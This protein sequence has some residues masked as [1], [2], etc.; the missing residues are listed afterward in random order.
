MKLDKGLYK[1]T[2][3]IDQIDGS[4][5][6]ARNILINKIQGAVTNELGF[7]KVHT[8]TR[9]IIGSIPITDDEIIIFSRDDDADTVINNRTVATYYVAIPA[10]M[11][12]DITFTYVNSVGVT[13]SE[14]ISVADLPFPSGG[15]PYTYF[16]NGGVTIT[17]TNSTTPANNFTVVFSDTSNT[18]N[19]IGNLTFGVETGSA[20][21][22]IEEVYYSEIGRFKNNSYTKILESTKL[23]FSSE[24]FIK[25]CYVLNYKKEVII[26]FT[27][28]K[29]PPKI[30]NIDDLPFE[31]DPTSKKLLDEN[32]LVLSYLFPEYSKPRI[33]YNTIL[34]NGGALR[35]G[36]YFLSFAYEL[37]DGSVT[38]YTPLEG[39][40]IVTNSTLEL[41]GS[42]RQDQQ[43]NFDLTSEYDG[44]EPDT[45]TSK[46]IKFI[47]TDIDTRYK[48]VHFSVYKKIG[49]VVTS[50]FV[51]R[52]EIASFVNDEITDDDSIE[53]S[54]DTNVSNENNFEITYTG[55]ETSSTLLLEDISVGNDTYQTAKTIT[56]FDS[57]LFLGNVTTNA[58]FNY[59]PYA[60][61][62][63]AHWE[64]DYVDINSVKGSYKNELFVYNKRGFRPDEVY[65]FYIAFLYNDG[66]WSGAYHIP[67]RD[68][69]LVTVALKDQNNKY[70]NPI[71]I[72]ETIPLK[73]IILGDVSQGIITAGDRTKYERIFNHD[74]GINQDTRYFQTRETARV[75]GRLGFWQNEN[76]K[77]PLDPTTWGETNAGQPVRHHKMPNYAT[78]NGV[79]TSFPD[80]SPD[81]DY[82]G[83]AA[84]TGDLVV[85]A[86]MD[87]CEID[88]RPSMPTKG[89][90]SFWAD[91][92]KN[93]PHNTSYTRRRVKHHLYLYVGTASPTV[94]AGY[95][96]LAETYD[97][98][99]FTDTSGPYAHFLSGTI[100]IAGNMRRGG[101]EH[102]A[103]TP[104][105][106]SAGTLTDLQALYPNLLT[107]KNTNKLADG[108]EMEYEGC[109][110]G[111][112]LNTPI[113][114]LPARSA[115]QYYYLHGNNIG[116]YSDSHIIG[117]YYWLWYKVGGCLKKA[118]QSAIY[119]RRWGEGKR[120]M[121]C[122]RVVSWLDYNHRDISIF[123][124]KEDP[125]V[126]VNWWNATNNQVGS[127]NGNGIKTIRA[128][129]DYNYSAS[130]GNYTTPSF[131]S[132][133]PY[134]AEG[135]ADIK[136]TGT[137]PHVTSSGLS[138][139]TFDDFHYNNSGSLANQAAIGALTSSTM[140]ATSVTGTTPYGIW[141]NGNYTYTASE[142]H[143]LLF[144][145]KYGVEL[146]TK[147]ISISGKPTI[148]HVCIS[149]I[150]KIS[151]Q[152]VSDESTWTRTDVFRNK[153]ANSRSL[154]TEAE[155]NSQQ[156]DTGY[157]DDFKLITST[158]GGDF[159]SEDVGEVF[160]PDFTAAVTLQVGDVI[161]FYHETTCIVNGEVNTN[162]PSNTTLSNR[163]TYDFNIQILSYP[164][165]NPDPVYGPYSM[166][167]SICGVRFSNIEIPRELKDRVQGYQFFYARRDERNTRVYDQSIAFH[168]APHALQPNEEG[169][170]AGHLIPLG[171]LNL[172]ETNK[173]NSTGTT[174]VYSGDHWSQ[175]SFDLNETGLSKQHKIN[176][177]SLRFHGFDVLNTKPTIQSAYVNIVSVLSGAEYTD[178]RTINHN[179]H[180]A[181]S[182]ADGLTD[183]TTFSEDTTNEGAL[184]KY[185][186][187]LGKN[188]TIDTTVQASYNQIWNRAGTSTS[189]ENN[190]GFS[191]VDND[192]N[193]LR[194]L[195][196]P[197]Y[198]PGDGIVTKNSITVNNTWGEECFH[199][200]IVHYDREQYWSEIDHHTGFKEESTEDVV[201]MGQ[202]VSTAGY[203][204]PNGWR[205]IK[206]HFY[207]EANGT[208]SPFE[209]ATIGP[210]YNLV[211]LLSYKT[212]VYDS[213]YD[214]TLVNTLGYN[215]ITNS[216]KMKLLT[217]NSIIKNTGIIYGGDTF[218]GMYGVRLTAPVYYSEGKKTHTWYYS[219]NKFNAVK[220]IFYFPRYSSSNTSLRNDKDAFIDS[221]YPKCSVG[222]MANG[223]TTTTIN[224]VLDQKKQALHNYR[225]RAVDA[226]NTNALH[227]NEDYT[228]INSY[229]TLTTYDNRN[230]FL[231]KFPYRVIRSQA[232]GQENK[233]MSLKVFK[234][235]DYYEMP[236]DRGS[237]VNLEGMGKHLLIHHEFALFRTT[238]QDVL[239]TDTA[240]A[241]LGTGD[242]FQFAPTELLTSEN[243]YAGTQNLS[244]ILV[245]KAGYSFVD[246]EQGKVFIVSDKLEEISNRGMRN[247]FQNNLDFENTQQSSYDTAFNLGGS[248]YTTA[249][250]E[251]NNRLILSKKDLKLK[252][253]LYTDVSVPTIYKAATPY[254]LVDSEGNNTG[255]VG[256]THLNVYD[257]WGNYLGQVSNATNHPNYV[258]PIINTD[259]CPG[260]PNIALSW[261]A[262]GAFE[263]AVPTLNVTLSEI[264]EVDFY[265]T[266]AYSGSFSAP[267]DGT[268]PATAI[269]IPQGYTTVAV[270]GTT[271]H[272]SVIEGTET[273]VAT[274]TDVEKYAVNSQGNQANISNAAVIT[275]GTA[276]YNVYDCPVLAN[277]SVADVS[278]N[279]T[280]PMSFAI[281]TLY[282]I[283]VA[284]DQSQPDYPNEKRILTTQGTTQH[285]RRVKGAVTSIIYGFTDVHPTNSIIKAELRNSLTNELLHSAT[286]ASGIGSTSNATRTW[287]ADPSPS[288]SGD[289]V[290]PELKILN[291]SSNLLSFKL[292]ITLVEGVGNDQVLKVNNGAAIQVN[293][294]AVTNIF[295]FAN[296]NFGTT[297]GNSL[298]NIYPTLAVLTS[299]PTSGYLRKPG[300]INALAIGDNIY[301]PADGN[302]NN[303][304]LEYVYN[305]S[306]SSTASYDI[307]TEW[308]RANNFGLTNPGDLVKY[309]YMPKDANGTYSNSTTIQNTSTTTGNWLGST[310][311]KTNSG[312]T[313]EAWWWDGSG[314]GIVKKSTN[315]SSLFACIDD[316]DSQ[317]AQG[318]KITTFTH[319]NNQTKTPASGRHWYNPGIVYSQTSLTSAQSL[320]DSFTYSVSKSICTDTA[321]VSLAG[322]FITPDTYIMLVF[323]G[324][325]SMDDAV[326][327]LQT[328]AGGSYF[329]SGSTTVKNPN[330]LRAVLQ[331]FY[332]TGQTELQGNTDSSTNG[333]DAYNSHVYL[334]IENSEKTW[335]MLANSSSLQFRNSSDTVLSSSRTGF[336]TASGKD[337][338]DADNIITMVFQDESTP[339]AA[340]GSWSISGYRDTTGGATHK[341]DLDA[342]KAAISGT[343][344]GTNVYGHVF[345]LANSNYAGLKPFL[346]AVETSTSSEMIGID[347]GVAYD[348]TTTQGSLANDI[349]YSYDGNITG[350]SAYFRGLVVDVLEDFGF[351]IP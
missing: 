235:N 70:L 315:S 302:K 329:Q 233:T 92:H 276:T 102:N 172:E 208:D 268:L 187:L 107:M 282:G 165:Q 342:Y 189:I 76:E 58:D 223:N 257:Q 59:Q 79:N 263:G 87:E 239:A 215:K 65:A 170:Y 327:A 331:D 12:G 130:L 142:A 345:H 167:A 138:P 19:Q 295:P 104:Q 91:H 182:N 30:L 36:A 299:L 15:G 348:L 56:Y 316:V 84:G 269:T 253:T 42:Y 229:N 320:T 265:V 136:Q 135:V 275:V 236:K 6:N 211:D 54:D 274:I 256:Y 271:T 242:I 131:I 78:L 61:N 280:E 247:W 202:T 149:G 109:G 297:F 133:Q 176:P 166:Y 349:T 154:V 53:T 49:G 298:D 323:D 124:D 311:T 283:Q 350:T 127:N 161:Q 126:I 260:K 51:K 137:V 139:K 337:F 246:R 69:M 35:S 21:T 216:D 98:R 192:F 169:S 10:N 184:G 155:H 203:K 326:P 83:P 278:L 238:T 112:R 95:Y 168:G 241:S 209:G 314:N 63:K 252:T 14:T 1:D 121:G 307:I 71:T 259:L 231:D 134:D 117:H 190:V 292:T 4:Y 75:D 336:D 244:S 319:Y 245:S 177:N 81:G 291:T 188:S 173:H 143:T 289:V 191:L 243:G 220:N 199:A 303:V 119:G 334:L 8:L 7:D 93:R 332:A 255:Y 273:I 60:M 225:A 13:E 294:G 227:Y 344:S 194:Q 9:K 105:Q 250:D 77:Y 100:D 343:P 88:T 304:K 171:N 287:T 290:Y 96:F 45:P 48:Y 205:K 82:S 23:K 341:A 156:N 321:T 200:Q 86:F 312:S 144:K 28:D 281:D 224:S 3:A 325:G 114:E 218:V 248:G 267:S 94:P 317:N 118:S 145:G 222:S 335:A 116:H 24:S 217:Q 279:G 180:N 128:A 151:K 125:S 148:D 38:N 324:S 27:D 115:Q 153:E 162:V 150:R 108:L 206:S 286:G 32:D 330:T 68:K 308:T 301:K 52:I 34:D 277:D 120:V 132:S 141:S 262:V 22:I 57:K 179:S 73:D 186:T 160:R 293:Y 66:T 175:T 306:T 272:D 258:P 89:R 313:S 26:A 106:V 157:E 146:L 163:I 195:Q 111:K 55:K 346:Q 351:N 31:V 338:E 178:V 237:I 310:C 214:Q 110:M 33:V 240:Q 340:S 284:E 64:R 230:R 213:F 197:S 62:I 181:I 196:S 207:N 147:N 113:W 164:Y 18:N 318:T 333:A 5:P 234:T 212:D 288:T 140:F 210:S 226:T 74:L 90:M 80:E 47:L 40:F 43:S 285:Y 183:S 322:Q 85:I 39:P 185:T 17:Q 174:A 264:Q 204:I 46:S 152:D 72:D 232:Y 339:Y 129:A 101:Y 251:D 193:I 29:S 20:L 122:S 11:T 266:V 50:E 16:I 270:S 347:N 41:S 249:F 309:H 103:T 2:H 123:V 296:D 201:I 44:C 300:T 67:G 99:E 159:T 219:D 254:C 328:M 305:G 37:E 25:G 158:K 228:S 97:P 261:N 221:Y 198:L